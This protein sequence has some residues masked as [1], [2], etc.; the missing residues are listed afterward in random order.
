MNFEPQ[1]RPREP[2]PEI[3]GYRIEGMIGRGSTGVVYRARQLAVDRAVALKVL[4]PELAG[5]GNAIR[6]LQREARTTARLTHPTIVSAIDMGETRGRW[7][8]AMELVEGESLAERLRTKGKLSERET[9]RLLIPL[10]E[11]LQHAHEHGVVHRDIKPANILVDTE[12]RPHLVDLGLALVEDDPAITRH[13]GTM[14]TPHY[15]SP[16]QARNPAAV[17]IRSDIWSLGATF[18]HAVCGRPPFEGTS[19]AEILSGVLYARVQEPGELAP[20]LQR[21]FALVLRKC[22]S[23]APERRY[24]TPKELLEDLELLRE[25]RD[26]KIRAST[27]DPVAGDGGKRKRILLGAGLVLAVASGALAIWWPFGAK[28]AAGAGTETGASLGPWVELEGIAEKGRRSHDALAAAITEVRQLQPVPERHRARY[29]EVV[30]SLVGAYHVAVDAFGTDWRREV[31]QALAERDYVRAASLASRTELE[32][33]LRA[34]FAPSASQLAELFERLRDD[35]CRSKLE[36]AVRAELDADV[37]AARALVAERARPELDQRLAA[38]AFRTARAELERLR[39]GFQAEL[40]R[41]PRKLA[42]EDAARLAREV[43]GAFAPLF[44][45]LDGRWRALDLELADFVV[46]RAEEIEGRLRERDLDGPADAALAALFE[47]ELDARGLAPTEFV[48][49]VSRKALDELDGRSRAL[50]EL[51]GRFEEEDAQTWAFITDRESADDWRARD[52]AGVRARW[53]AGLD[54]PWTVK[55]ADRIRLEVQWAE[56]LD[57]VLRRAADQIS[58]SRGKSLALLIGT[59]QTEGVVTVAEDPLAQGF[60]FRAG[61]TA[62]ERRLVLRASADPKAVLLGTD[63]IERLAGLAQAPNAA[64][65]P[66]DRLLRVLFR[67]REG[68]VQGALAALRSG[69]LPREE[70]AEL[71]AELERRLRQSATAFAE[72]RSARLAE[73]KTLHNLI[74][75]TH[76]DARDGELVVQRIDDLLA[77]YGD[78]E[79]VRGERSKL[80]AWRA[81]RVAPPAP[82]STVTLAERFGAAE[83]ALVDGRAKLTWRMDAS[84]DEGFDGGDWVLAADGWRAG[85][86]RSRDDLFAA[87]RWPRVS[88]APFANFDR[89]VECEVEF[90]QP[91]SSGPPRLLVVTV[92]GWHVAIAGAQV[93]GEPGRWR[94][95]SGELAELV[96]GVFAG[97]GRALEP[98]AT[99]AVH[100]L[101]VRL[102]HK[103]GRIEVSLDGKLLGQESGLRPTD[104][105]ANAEL[106]VRSLEVLR[107]VRVGASF[108][109]R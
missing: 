74:L 58:A 34:R 98:L 76:D 91:R 57:E 3:P 77:R 1:P 68:D 64:D 28:P 86:L 53:Q 24:Q 7:W 101:R 109:T 39:D 40:V 80:E 4:H 36:S 19:V 51:Q 45:E 95:S 92:A 50:A 20:N 41:A 107:L 43:V 44:D 102:T 97:R 67:Y 18:Y 90:E 29:D 49:T 31:D 60:G 32:G 73:A 63:A 14:G 103:R 16:E 6:R 99:D 11:A 48:D 42:V 27:L 54:A 46:G 59:I 65:V 30:A 21:G 66:R 78:L 84:A 70:F 2:L 5:K 38:S 56:L 81:A 72:E 83:L 47:T 104:V 33:R 100:V 105:A 88:L 9:L 15:I 22:L 12:G 87:G 93:P 23:R 96:D 85:S 52:Y 71:V 61:A 82:I 55:I 106:M 37:V 26:V 94:A 69:A 35:E 89:E 108:T 17:D 8:Y 10:V 75:R 13:G 25:R 62:G 79:F